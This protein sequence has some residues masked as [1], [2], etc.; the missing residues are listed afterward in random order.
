[1]PDLNYVWD[2][3]RA[4][5]TDP[6]MDEGRHTH[7]WKVIV[8]TSAKPFRDGRSIRASL[9]TILDVWEGKDLPPELWSDHDL[10]CYVLASTIWRIHGNADCCG[11]RVEREEGFGASVGIT[12]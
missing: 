5:H 11:V 7:T 8:F 9:R 6:Y 12:S 1:M 3:L 10:A 2:H 4:F